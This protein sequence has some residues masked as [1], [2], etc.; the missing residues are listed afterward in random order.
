MEV[1]EELHH[2]YLERR[3]QDLQVCRKNLR[4]HHFEDLEKLGHRLK[5]NG[6]TFGYQELSDIGSRLELAAL[7]ENVAEL[8]QAIHDFELW[9]NR[10]LN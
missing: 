3:K 7:Q 10:H 1:P 9:L 4:S 8:E 2:R 5:G 6:L